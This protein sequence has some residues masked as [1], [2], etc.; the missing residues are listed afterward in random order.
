[1]RHVRTA[2][3]LLVACSIASGCQQTISTRD[4]IVAVTR[5]CDGPS[6][7]SPVMSGG[8]VAYNAD[9]GYLMVVSQRVGVDRPS[10]LGTWKWS[11]TWSRLTAAEDA[12]RGYA[13]AYDPALHMTLLLGQ[14]TMGWDG[15]QWVDLHAT[16]PINLGGTS[17][18][19]DA[20]RSVMVLIDSYG[21]GVNTWTYDGHSWRKVATTGPANEEGAGA[22]YDPRTKTVVLFGGYTP[23]PDGPETLTWSWDG[24]AWTRLHPAKSP[25]NGE[26]TLAYDV[27]TSQMIMVNQLSETWTWDGTTWNQLD[28]AAPGYIG[29]TPL[30]YDSAG[31]QLILWQTGM[32]WDRSQTWIFNGTW[33]QLP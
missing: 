15:G 8:L 9:G 13:M 28:S 24:R 7:P 2:G 29:A 30:V 5:Q 14:K 23:G 17:F 32:F 11:C 6:N 19:Y 3:A 16:P 18:V 26:A 33:T 1:M 10:D 12:P 31:R 25:Q 22:A 20:A 27:A 21:T 4:P